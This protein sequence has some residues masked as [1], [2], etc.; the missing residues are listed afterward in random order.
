MVD[1]DLVEIVAAV[2]VGIVVVAL[3]A[4]SFVVRDTTDYMVAV[5][6]DIVPEL[7]LARQRQRQQQL[8]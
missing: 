5:V 7:V 2:F 1:N 8:K 4:D 6:A 3:V